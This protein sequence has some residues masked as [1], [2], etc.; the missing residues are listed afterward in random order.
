MET[1]IRSK[2]L[3]EL[4]SLTRNLSNYYF[5]EIKDEDPHRIFKV[6]QVP[7]NNVYWLIGHLAN[8]EEELVLRQIGEKDYYVDW[9]PIF[10]YGSKVPSKGEGPDFEEVVQHYKLIHQVTKEK[11]P[12]FADNLLDTMSPTG[13]KIGRL[14]TISDSIMHAIRHEGCHAGHLGWL[15]KLYKNC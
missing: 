9:L 6:D 1:T 14:E 15:M 5:K 11:L 8:C 12:L 3:A 2:Q 4:F 13:F 7:L 10:A